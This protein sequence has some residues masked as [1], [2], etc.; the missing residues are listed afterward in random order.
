MQA[1]KKFGS[2]A[3]VFPEF[4]KRRCASDSRFTNKK[5]GGGNYKMIG[6]GKI[7]WIS[8]ECSYTSYLEGCENNVTAH[9]I[10]L[11]HPTCNLQK[12]EEKLEV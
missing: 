10:C 7:S 12:L 2:L 3:K 9:L 11:I 6:G 1:T 8:F 5:I 4:K